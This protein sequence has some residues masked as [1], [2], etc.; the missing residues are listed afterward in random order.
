MKG[1]LH[2][3]LQSWNFT[4]LEDAMSKKSFEK[5]TFDLYFSQ[6]TFKVFTFSNSVIG[7]C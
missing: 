2:H 4:S 5:M 6:P 3:Q 7:L 1:T